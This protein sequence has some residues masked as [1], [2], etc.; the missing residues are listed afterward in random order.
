[1]INERQTDTVIDVGPITSGGRQI[2]LYNMYLYGPTYS[3]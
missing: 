1:M 3:L 2:G